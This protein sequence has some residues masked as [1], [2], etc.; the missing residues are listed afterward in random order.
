MAKILMTV[1]IILILISVLLPWLQKLGL[2]TLPGDIMIKRK[3]FTFYFP[4][5]TSIIVSILISVIVWFFRK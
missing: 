5:I 2:G 4:I 1:G 3:H